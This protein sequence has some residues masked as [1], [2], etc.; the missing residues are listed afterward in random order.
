MLHIGK[1]GLSNIIPGTFTLQAL[2][3]C[4]KP[5]TVSVVMR[6]LLILLILVVSLDSQAPADDK[7]PPEVNLLAMGDWGA[8]NAFQRQI[9]S[10]MKTYVAGKHIPLD[11]VLLVG[12]N[13][14][15][16]LRGTDDPM[17]QTVFERM[18][19]PAVFNAPFYAVFGNHDYEHGKAQIEFQYAVD[20]PDSRWKLPALW[21][22]RDI[23]ADHP[24]VT[25]LMLNSNKDRLS[26]QQWDAQL[27][28]L[29]S[30]LE[31]PRLGKWII[32]A[33][34]HPLFSNGGH[35]DNGVLQTQWGSLFKAHNVDF[36]ICGHDHDIEHLE[37]PGYPTS[38]ILA[39]GGG[40]D[41]REMRYDR[42][43]PY[44]QSTYGFVHLR[45][46]DQRADVTYIGAGATILHTFSKDADG[47]SLPGEQVQLQPSST[48]P[49]IPD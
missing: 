30:E 31:K 27:K 20:H 16:R 22:R 49:I 39:G 9:A 13:F 28:W 45:L 47:K 44:S 43:G 7:Q 4:S 33:A 32:A 6:R 12:D 46:S 21:Y 18:Y 40:A 35:G 48:K 19:D 14:Y 38:F 17:W 1:I 34:H 26:N 25:L 3:S 36:Y 23:P 42:S 10:S 29:S 41:K 8:N 37:R 5:D 11:A 2:A 24:L 15:V